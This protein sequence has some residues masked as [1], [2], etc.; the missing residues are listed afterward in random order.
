M[1]AKEGN[2]HHLR[3]ASIKKR[4]DYL[5]AIASGMTNTDAANVAGVSVETVKYWLKSDKE[6]RQSLD[7][8]RISRDEVR[9]G[10]QK[11]EKYNIGFEEFSETYLGMK[12]FPHQRNF[13]SLLEKGEPEWLHDN[14]TYEPG[15]KNRILINIPPEHAKSTTITVN[16]STY[17]V[18]MDPNVRIIIVSKTLY[19]ARE[20]IYAIKQRLSHPRWLKMQ[21]M[22]GP[23]G[24]WK[25]DADTWRT[26]TVYLGSETR[27]SSEKDPTLQALGM[28]GQ[29]YGARADLIILDDCVTNSNAHEWEKQIK[30]LQQE[31]ITRLGK[32]G[33]LLVVGTRVAANDLYR[34]LRNKEHWSGGKSPFTHLAMPAVLKFDSKPDKWET[35]WAKSDRPW[36]G[37][38]DAEPDEN[39]LYPKWDG[40]ALFVRR[41]E[42]TPSTW[43]MVYQQQDVEEDS[44]FPALC[45]QG[46]VNGMRKVGRL[47]PGA[48]GHPKDYGNWRIVMG[49]DPAMSGATAAVIVAVDMDTK[50]RYVLDA[51]NMT[52]PTPA[53]I[54][55][56][57]EDWAIKYQPNVVVAE[58]NAF[59]LFLTKDEAIRD[60]L[61]SR[62]IQF[63]E[64]FT[65]NN[66]WD[67]DFGVAAMAP[68]FGTS[69]ANRFVKG[70]N[71]LEL[72]SS[73][74][75]EG[76]KALIN[77]LITWKPNL[78]KKQPT[79]CVMALWFTEIISREWLERG[80][81]AQQFSHS[82]WHSRKQ[83][84]NRFV[85][86]L[87][88]AYAEQQQEVFYV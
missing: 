30:W 28:G 52:E 46:S 67:T 6:F 48:A 40:P 11:S 37:E 13:I 81:Y 20:F 59:Q 74:N 87:D 73:E 27:D 49:I 38:D 72:P 65:G 60:F 58:K 17:R 43:A 75:S 19:K 57:I 5:A 32:N 4:K 76:I 33:K 41:S 80:Q 64:H 39:G 7:D 86:D 82:R 50:R 78:N 56:L 45:V 16:Y 12:V 85:V 2:A 83:L 31:V 10:T 70:S 36:D 47:N 53:K 25:E 51:Q 9:E 44:I 35:L 1:A 22:Y 54:R 24:G 61:A 68:L 21:Q 23:G 15:S 26:D 14:M 84:N 63:R 79:D 3:A 55:Q 71:L 18:A 88:E 29:I 77:Q 42:V 66:K 8:A 62:G 34:E 69:D